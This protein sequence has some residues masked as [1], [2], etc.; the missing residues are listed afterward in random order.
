MASFLPKAERRLL[1]LFVFLLMLFI[2]GFRSGIGTDYKTYLDFFLSS[3]PAEFDMEPPYLLIKK[4][5]DIFHFPS[6]TFF[7]LTAFLTLF[8]VYKGLLRYATNIELAII[9]YV[10]VGL[11]TNSFNIIRQLIAAS[12]YLCY[13]LKYLERG[14]FKRYFG[15][16]LFAAI[17]HF[18]ALAL[19]PVYFLVRKEYNIAWLSG[20]L[21]L[22]LVFNLGFINVGAISSLL[23]LLPAKYAGYLQF[24]QHYLSELH[25]PVLLKFVNNA[26]KMVIVYLLFYYRKRLIALNPINLFIINFYFFFTIYTI[27]TRGLAEIQ[28]LG[29]YFYIFSPLAVSLLPSL[30][31]NKYIRILII[32]TIVAVYFVYFIVIILKSNM[33]EVVP[34]QTIL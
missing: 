12:V 8:F 25:E 15:V 18:S 13:A 1:H 20:A 30:I 17:F 2:A 29:Y 22:A 21:L 28:R 26:D 7:L 5:A 32:I 23:F 19:L 34:Y 16:V 27:A 3:N 9:L 11:Y 6:A 14:D 24:L 33:G 31:N 4:I 10:L